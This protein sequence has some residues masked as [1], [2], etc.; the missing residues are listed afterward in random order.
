[1]EKMKHRVLIEFESDSIPDGLTDEMAALVYR[2][3]GNGCCAKL[4]TGNNLKVNRMMNEEFENHVGRLFVKPADT[5]GRMVHAAM[6][7]AGEA[8]EVVDA[9]KKT[10]IYGK[11]L[12][13][14][15][16]LEECGD[17]LFYIS[18]LLAETGFTIEDAM[19]HNMEKLAKRYPIGYTDKAAI[20]RADKVEK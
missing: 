2:I 19:A 7:I 20:E 5:T 15:N 13:R 1:M 4:L 8:G 17:L 6:G 14:E 16:V 12:D 10:W 11:E 18:A 9:V 3:T